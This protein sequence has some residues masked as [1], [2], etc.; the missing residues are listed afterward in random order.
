MD[1]PFAG[2]AKLLGRRIWRLAIAVAALAA[3]FSAWAGPAGAYRT[4]I[5]EAAPFTYDGW[6]PL[7]PGEAG[8]LQAI[9]P[10]PTDPDILLAGSDSLGLQLTRD[11]GKTWKVVN[12]GAR[13]NP[14]LNSQGIYPLAWDPRRPDTVYAGRAGFVVKSTDGGE[15]WYTYGPNLPA[16]WPPLL[17]LTF[18]PDDSHVIYAV[19]SDGN[20]FVT[21]DACRS[22]EALAPLP[23]GEKAGRF[24]IG[25]WFSG[26]YLDVDPQSPPENRTLFAASPLGLAKST[27]NGRTWQVKPLGEHDAAVNNVRVVPDF[28]EGRPAVVVAAD[29]VHYTAAEI[30]ADPA[31]RRGDVR[32]AG[33]VYVSFDGGETFEPRNDGLPVDRART[34]SL[35]QVHPQDP[36]TL[37]V[38]TIRGGGHAIGAFKSTDGGRSWRLVT[39]KT[40]EGH[41]MAFGWMNPNMPDLADPSGDVWTN[42]MVSEISPADPDLLFLRGSGYVGIMKST[43]RGESWEQIYSDPVPGDPGYWRGRGANLAYAH[44][45]AF[46]PNDPD[47]IYVDFTDFGSH[48]SFDAGRTWRY[49]FHVRWYGAGVGTG[50]RWPGGPTWRVGDDVRQHIRKFNPETRQHEPDGIFFDRSNAFR[51]IVD[52]GDPDTLYILPLRSGEWPAKGALLK[53]TDRGDTYTIKLPTRRHLEQGAKFAVGDL[54][55]DPRGG[56]ATRRLYAAADRFGVYA[57]EDSGRTWRRSS[58]GIPEGEVIVHL[59]LC[60]GRPDTVLAA[61]GTRTIGYRYYREEV[62][63]GGQFGRIYR[64]DDQGR[65]WRRIFEGPADIQQIAVHPENP[66]VAYAAVYHRADGLAR[67]AGLLPGGIYRTSDGGRNWQRVFGQP[68]I[69]ALAIRP[70]RPETVF[71]AVLERAIDDHGRGV[72]GDPETFA[73]GIYRSLDGGDTWEDVSGAMAGLVTN[74]KCLAIN[75]AD[76]EVLYVGTSGGLW[77]K[78][79]P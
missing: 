72:T 77:R 65:T 43:D 60:P 22:F 42:L 26:R 58:E 13:G 40:G 14:P 41:N 61:S 75:P 23:T 50:L 74:F 33:G 49:Y 78:R 63:A 69:V 51:T 20:V 48:V 64:S 37:F 55:M 45:V 19:Q 24:A 36:Q 31:L 32:F 76:P 30:R 6:E 28:E 16:R 67:R 12:Q 21:R 1:I 2:S 47:A 53:S 27:D 11:G 4:P 35:L 71:A 25:R 34:F 3:A 15:S 38:S 46:D 62:V 10:H 56:P 54:A 9:L 73:P 79:M 52:P 57:T 39:R 70:D 5:G 66:D 59:A 8:G 29:S 7:G 17:D 44:S 68:T 18:D